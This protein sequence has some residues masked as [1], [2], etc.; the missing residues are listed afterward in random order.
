MPVKQEQAAIGVC[1]ATNQSGEP[2][3]APP[4]RGAKYCSLH[5]VLGRAAELGKRGGQKN[6]SLA[7]HYSDELI[8]TPETAQDVR[9]FLAETMVQIRVGRMNPRVGTTLAYVGM[10]L[11]KAIQ[12]ADLEPRLRALEGCHE[13]GSPHDGVQQTPAVLAPELTPED[14]DR[15]IEA[16]YSVSSAG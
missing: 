6:R 2:C 16:D 10:V 14:Y 1:Q 5:L 9:K 7:G 8:A 13:H 15:M 3:A 4:I 12:I 11:L